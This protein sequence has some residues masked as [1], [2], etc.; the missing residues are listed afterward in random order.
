MTSAKIRQVLQLWAFALA[1]SA[2]LA[3]AGQRWS[4][5]LPMRD[6]LIWALL[7]LPSLG[8]VLLLLRRWSLPVDPELILTG[9]ERESEDSIQ[10]QT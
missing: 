4:E 5:P 9:Q 1:I 7:L 2:A 3:A 10:E 6:W 8:M